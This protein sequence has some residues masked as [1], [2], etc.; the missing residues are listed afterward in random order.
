MFLLLG[1]SD[2]T[3]ARITSSMANVLSFQY[4]NGATATI[5]VSK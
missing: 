5:L 2:D 4:Y 1:L 3:V